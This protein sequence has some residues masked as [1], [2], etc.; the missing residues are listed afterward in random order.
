MRTFTQEGRITSLNGY[1]LP[2]KKKLTPKKYI[3]FRFLIPGTIPS[4]KNMIWAASNIDTMLGKLTSCKSVLEAIQYLKDNFKAYIKNSGK[5]QSWMAEIRPLII[6]QLSKE[7]QKHNMLWSK[8]FENVSIKIYHYWK[9]DIERDL[10]NKQS[11]IYDLFKECGII[12]NDNWQ[13]L[14][15]IHSECEDYREQITEAM[16]T[17][18]VTARYY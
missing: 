15:Q 13:C 7:V 8:P 5:Y 17:V 16:T 12:E 3:T 4:K 1:F 9:D 18:D 2:P 6:E 10:D 11:S 14:G